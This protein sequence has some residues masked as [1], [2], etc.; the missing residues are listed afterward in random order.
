M[1]N[2]FLNEL[3]ELAKRD[4][5]IVFVTGDLGFSVVERYMEELPD[6]FVNAGVAEQNMIGL[7]AGM[8]LCGKIVFTYSIANFPTLRCLEQIRNDVCYH[9][10]N[11]K[12]VSVGGG[13]AYG[14]LG[15]THHATE[16]LGV[17]RM[18]P[19]MVVVAPGDAIETRAAT[20]AIVAYPGPCYLRLGKAGEP[21]VHEQEITF[22][23]GRALIVRDGSDVTLISTG[24]MLHGAMGAAE[25]LAVDGVDVRVISM[26]TLEPLDKE[27]VFAAA[28]ETQAI[29]TLEEHSI[30]GGLGS[31][32]AELL[33]ESSER[34]PFR[35][36][37]VPHRFSPRVGSQEFMLGENGLDLEG[38]RATVADIIGRR[39]ILAASR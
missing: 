27:A 39:D 36:M 10:A 38:V 22:A 15:M 8:A 37:G 29:I 6:Q 26:H 34:V 4:P 11:V 24:G 16:D 21:I 18:L 1:R 30:V 9:G 32:V 20:R 25:S 12:V 17:M 23:L 13:F 28:R 3:F 14:S 2:A 33:A 5:R 7:A 35:R 19:N 31:A